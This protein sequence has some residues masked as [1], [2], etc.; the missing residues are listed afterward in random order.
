MAVLDQID[1]KRQQVDRVMGLVEWA[2]DL[3]AR[4]LGWLKK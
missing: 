3:L 2:K 4:I 1:E